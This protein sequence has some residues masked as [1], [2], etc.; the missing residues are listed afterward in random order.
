MTSVRSAQPSRYR[1]LVA[2]LWLA[3]TLGVLGGRL[4]QL[5]ILGVD[6]FR[7]RADGNRI[8]V[9]LVPAPR[10]IIRDRHGE[11]LAS[12]RLSYSVTLYPIQLSRQQ[13]AQVIDRL[14]ALLS[15]PPAEI[16]AKWQKA[17]NL[18]VRIMQD[19]DPKT[20]AIIAENQRKLPG[21]SIDPIT[22][23]YYPRGRFAAHL[24]GYTGEITDKELQ[25]LA[26]DG[27]RQGDIIGKTGLERVLDSELRGQPGRLQVEVDA[28]G[29]PVRT[30]AE[31][32]PVPGHD[33]TTTIDAGL[34]EVA[35]HELEGKVGAI[36]CM[37]PNSGE[38]LAMASKP[39]F[40]P[41]LF[42][43]R[44]RPQDWRALN[45]PVHP[46]LNRTISAVYPPGSTFK[47]VTTV[48]A[49]QQGI[50]RE[51]SPFL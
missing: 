21:V 15:I 18:P 24:L 40:D 42:A 30:L 31:I 35:E 44:M 32:P 7:E 19:V 23:R 13:T 9:T 43:G 36:V 50:V 17:G 34:Q 12:D 39:D 6:E 48:A 38:I 20:I 46:L 14:G 47:I 8:R 26:D 5:Q 28:R 10:G 22:V 45:S 1:T 11:L 51:D 49:M 3:A 2:G 27:Y 25:E 4:V 41:N 33:V 29:R 16:L 37:D